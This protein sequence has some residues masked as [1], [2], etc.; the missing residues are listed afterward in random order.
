MTGQGNRKTGI[1]LSL[2]I[3]ILFTC[4]YNLTYAAE[5]KD[6]LTT[7]KVTIK[8]ERSDR[9]GKYFSFSEGKVIIPE[10]DSSSFDARKDIILWSINGDV[11]IEIGV[12]AWIHIGKPFDEIK[13]APTAGYQDKHHDKTVCETLYVP[14]SLIKE[15]KATYC[16]KTEDGNYAKLNFT[17]VNLKEKTV[18]FEWVYQPDRSHKFDNVKEV[19]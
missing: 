2:T 4:S 14:I 11:E 18:T 17:E 3:A 19:E 8:T 5:Q 12:P 6:S 1:L 16:I 15:G 9:K 7:K 10:P 13:E